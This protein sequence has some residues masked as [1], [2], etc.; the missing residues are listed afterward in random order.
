MVDRLFV[1]FEAFYHI[2]KIHIAFP[3]CVQELPTP[4][5]PTGSEIIGLPN[6][7]EVLLIQ[8]AVGQLALFICGRTIFPVA[9]HHLHHRIHTFVL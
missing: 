4:F 7:S 8:L 3:D 1:M 6:I 5:L 2:G 9:L